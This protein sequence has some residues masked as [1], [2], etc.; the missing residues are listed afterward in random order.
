[1]MQLGYPKSVD[2]LT[3]FPSRPSKMA[4]S[5]PNA[6]LTQFGQ[7]VTSRLDASDGS[8]PAGTGF[9]G[10]NTCQARRMGLTVCPSAVVSAQ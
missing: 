5:Q 7:K 9:V 10:L 2:S 6:T 3:S 1:M 8:R 4:A